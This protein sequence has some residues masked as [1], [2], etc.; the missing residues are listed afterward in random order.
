MNHPKLREVVAHLH[1]AD[2]AGVLLGL[3]FPTD[4]ANHHDVRPGQ[5]S[6]AVKPRRIGA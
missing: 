1:R 4:R 5:G 6:F 2:F 3:S